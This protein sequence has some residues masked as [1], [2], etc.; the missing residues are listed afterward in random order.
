MNDTESKKPKA[1]D[2]LYSLPESM[3]RKKDSK[4]YPLEN[5]Q[6]YGISFKKKPDGTIE[7]NIFGHP[8]FPL[9]K[10][11]MIIGS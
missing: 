10:V 1:R 11:F 9:S 5:I 7:L 4:E 8:C 2:F 6:W 3:T